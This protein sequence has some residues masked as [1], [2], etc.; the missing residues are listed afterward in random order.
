MVEERFASEGSTGLAGPWEA[1]LWGAVASP[2]LA[3]G[4]DSPGSGS[5]LFPPPFPPPL[6]PPSALP[7]LGLFA[8]LPVPLP[9][10]LSSFFSEGTRVLSPSAVSGPSALE[11]AP[12]M[13]TASMSAVIDRLDL[14]FIV[15][16]PLG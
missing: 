2:L 13:L 16:V 10:P 1:K 11:Q 7:G 6:P 15:L 4:G 8:P 14:S 12:S 5:P 3:E 9:W